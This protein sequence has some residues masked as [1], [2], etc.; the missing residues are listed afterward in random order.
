MPELFARQVYQ[1]H[2]K[3]WKISPLMWGV[4]VCPQRCFTK[5]K[6]PPFSHTCVHTLI[7]SPQWKPNPLHISSSDPERNVWEVVERHGSS[8]NNGS[9]ICGNGWGEISCMAD[10]MFVH[11]HDWRQATRSLMLFYLERPLLLYKAEERCVVWTHTHTYRTYLKNTKRSSLIIMSQMTGYMWRRTTV[12]P[13]TPTLFVSESC[14]PWFAPTWQ[15]PEP[16]VQ[17]L[18]CN[19]CSVKRWYTRADRTQPCLFSLQID[20]FYHEP[21]PNRP[22]GMDDER[23]RGQRNV[24]KKRQKGD[25][26]GTPPL[27]IPC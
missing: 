11:K 12:H 21:V 6:K 27:H 26:Q 13:E 2:I 5:D 10:V 4:S 3:E 23:S 17:V 20:T 19:Y 9:R 18:V 16:T 22:G 25:G 24:A 14:K 15:R 7:N 1:T 8:N